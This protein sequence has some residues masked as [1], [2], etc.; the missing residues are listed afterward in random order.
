MRTTKQPK[1]IVV[2]FSCGAASA[3]CAD[4]AIRKYRGKVPIVLAYTDPGTYSEG[5]IGEHPDNKRFLADCERWLDHPVTIMKSEKYE[6]P[7]DVFNKRRYIVGVAGAPCTTE[8]K[9]RLREGFQDVGDLQVFGFTSEE[10]KRADR[11]RGNNPE[12][13]LWTPLIEKM[14]TK[15]DTLAYLR[16]AGIEIP[17][18]YKKGYRNNN[19]IGCVKG[20]SGYWNKIRVDYPDIFEATA[21][22]ERDI[23]AAICKRYEGDKRITVYLDELPPDAGNYAAEPDI[24]CGLLCQIARTEEFCEEGAK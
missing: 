11:F 9:K 1:R 21:K 16:D 4:I 19:C 8:L 2:W 14:I 15:A 17:I 12:V 6:N 18:L 7:M 10:A 24:E 13:T 3:V 5:E 22:M 20:Q 23:G